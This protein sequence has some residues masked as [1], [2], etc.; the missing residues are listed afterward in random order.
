MEKIRTRN[1]LESSFLK[2]Q[3]SHGALDDSYSQV[4]SSQLSST[5]GEATILESLK[6]I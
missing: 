3:S 4:N 2:K 1:S 5:C 6:K